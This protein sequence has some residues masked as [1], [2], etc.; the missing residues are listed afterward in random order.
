[1]RVLHLSARAPFA[2]NIAS[3]DIQIVNGET[4]SHAIPRD[5]TFQWLKNF[6]KSQENAY[7]SFDVLHIHTV[8]L[9]DF[10]T[11][12]ETLELCTK[13][14]KGILFTYH[15][16]RP[17][18]SHDLENFYKSLKTLHSCKA[19]FTTLTNGAR[20]QLAKDTDIPE[21]E[22]YVIS[23][24]NVLP[25]DST[26]WLTTSDSSPKL[27]HIFS[28]HGGFR[29]NKNIFPAVLNF[30]FGLADKSARLDILTRGIG[31]KEYSESQ[32]VRET[33][34]LSSKS[35]NVRIS[36]H[37]FPSD[38]EIAQF[39]LKSDTI[40][41]PYLWGAHSGQLEL[42]FDLGVGAVATN[43]GFYKEQYQMM[44][45]YVA[46]PSWVDWTDGNEYQYGSRFLQGLLEQINVT[47]T[48]FEQRQDFYAFRR[49]ERVQILERYLEYYNEA[50]LR[51]Q[52][53]SENTHAITPNL[54]DPKP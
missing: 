45:S 46:E 48:A 34:N 32:D 25:L 5:T 42:A 11:F 28:I 36:F 40:L 3:P 19:I 26:L 52:T 38:H 22:I 6:L 44:P 50:C 39:V 18:F 21:S 47:R 1:M 2:R 29:P 24:G 51:Q 12:Q 30:V 8:E 54:T 13:N 37:P 23:H 35:P 27:S 33:L 15:D 7:K 31:S 14:K 49:E 16:T 20:S 10:Q 17:M 53:K 9:S 4:N 41:L 43:V